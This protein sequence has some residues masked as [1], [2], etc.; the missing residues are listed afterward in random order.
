MFYGCGSL[1]ELDLPKFNIDN[2]RSMYFTFVGISDKLRKKIK[3]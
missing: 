3:A 2:I 1:K